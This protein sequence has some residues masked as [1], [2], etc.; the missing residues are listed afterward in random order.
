MRTAPVWCYCT[1]RSGS[2]IFTVLS[3]DAC[4]SRPKP[5]AYVLQIDDTK[6][7]LDCGSPEWCNPEDHP[8]TGQITA[9][10]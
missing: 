9:P 2:M 5:L 3:G 6:V 1:R 10:H 4:S 7:L 8:T